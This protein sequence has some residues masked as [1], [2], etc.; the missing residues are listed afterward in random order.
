MC[1]V[2]IVEDDLGIREALGDLLAYEGFGVVQAE[3]GR[4]ALDLLREP[5]THPCLILLDLM[6]PVMD[7]W[8][9]L[10]AAETHLVTRKISVTIV[11]AVADKTRLPAGVPCLR[12]P[13]ELRTLL[14]IVTSHCRPDCASEA[15]P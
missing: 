10:R 13:V 8:Q 2:L 11:S 5:N 15:S 14:Q 1:S 6:M 7:G 4:Q 3:N 9:F 12:K